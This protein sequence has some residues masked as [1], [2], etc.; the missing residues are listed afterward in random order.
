TRYV[1][2]PVYGPF[3][4]CSRNGLID[5]NHVVGGGSAAGPS[6]HTG[7]YVG[8]DNQVTV[9]NNSVTNYVIGLV[10]TGAGIVD[11]GGDHVVS[12][13]KPALDNHSLGRTRR[14]GGR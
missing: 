2:N 9:R 7:I 3:P 1:D 5:F 14:A 4:V 6:L 12:G 13:H 11:L 10:P 8:D